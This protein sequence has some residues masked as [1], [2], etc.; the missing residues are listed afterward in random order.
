MGV[1][2]LTTFMHSFYPHPIPPPARGR[3][4]GYLARKSDAPHPQS[5]SR[6]EREDRL[7]PIDQ[8]LPTLSLFCFIHARKV[9]I[10]IHSVLLSEQ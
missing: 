5:L 6:G 8:P 9:S 4:H 1:E 3:G 7:L 2:F 10:L